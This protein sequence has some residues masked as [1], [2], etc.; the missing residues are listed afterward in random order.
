[1]QGNGYTVGFGTCS[2]KIA[3]PAPWGQYFS[4]GGV[5]VEAVESGSTSPLL[6]M[7]IIKCFSARN[8]TWIKLAFMRIVMFFYGLLSMDN[9]LRSNNDFNV[10]SGNVSQD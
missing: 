5:V 3:P 4:S 9:K 2:G 10:L 6:Y 7:Q 8:E 1:M